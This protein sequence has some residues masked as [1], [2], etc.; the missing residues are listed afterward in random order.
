MASAKQCILFYT[1]VFVYTRLM[2]EAIRPCPRPQIFC[3]SVA[4]NYKMYELKSHISI[5]F[6]C[7]RKSWNSGLSVRLQTERNFEL[8][9]NGKRHIISKT[10]SYCTRLLLLSDNCSSQ[11]NFCLNNW[12]FLFQRR[13]SSPL[14]KCERTHSIDFYNYCTLVS[15]PLMP[16]DI[17]KIL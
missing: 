3:T 5:L 11:N 1:T 17:K 9:T 6:A 14:L 12:T 10:D 16:K 2:Q 8:K 7:S 13:L 4:E 15:K